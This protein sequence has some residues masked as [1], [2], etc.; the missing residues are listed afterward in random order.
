MLGD[1]FVV[2]PTGSLDMDSDGMIDVE[3][4][5]HHLYFEKGTDETVGM[6]CDDFA[7]SLSPNQIYHPSPDLLPE[8]LGTKEDDL[9][10]DWYSDDDSEGVK[11]YGMGEG[12]FEAEVTARSG[13]EESPV[14]MALDET[15]HLHQVLEYDGDDED[16]GVLALPVNTD[17]HFLFE[18]DSACCEIA[19]VIL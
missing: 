6:S 7:N 9:Q 10:F 2:S 8:H 15:T 1:A 11:V 19:H 4:A 17:E 3:D 16:I 18:E 14:I 13:E 5:D 12:E